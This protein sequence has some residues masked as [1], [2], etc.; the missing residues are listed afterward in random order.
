MPPR[1]APVL[2][3]ATRSSRSIL[4]SLGARALRFVRQVCFRLPRAT[5][6]ATVPKEAKRNGRSAAPTLGAREDRCAQVEHSSRPVNIAV[7]GALQIRERCTR[8]QARRLLAP[9]DTVLL[10]TSSQPRGNTT[11]ATARPDNTRSTQTFSRHARVACPKVV[12]PGGF[13]LRANTTAARAPW[14]K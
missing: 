11:I 8:S 2:P 10:R 13:R 1:R 5:E 12:P 7:V 9:L 14:A 3:V 4:G 6:G